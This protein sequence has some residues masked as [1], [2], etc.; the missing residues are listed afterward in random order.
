MSLNPAE[1]WIFE[2]KSNSE[3]TSEQL[4][5]NLQKVQ[6]NDFF[7]HK[8]DQITGNNFGKCVNIL[9]F[10]GPRSLN[11]ALKVLKPI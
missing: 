8:H 11:M 9:L 3:T 4:Q 10:F 7:G 6:N 2:V 1:N 5:I